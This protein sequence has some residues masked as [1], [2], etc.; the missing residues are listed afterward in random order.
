MPEI[1]KKLSSTGNSGLVSSATVVAPSSAVE[2]CL[3]PSELEAP[4][5]VPAPSIVVSRLYYNTFPF[6]H[7]T[8]STLLLL[9]MVWRMTQYSEWERNQDLPFVCVFSLLQ[10]TFYKLGL[11][12][13]PLNGVGLPIIF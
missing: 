1:R 8:R 7:L 11:S 2:A 10:E 6:L 4:E 3:L 9:P 12:P 13:S 5:R